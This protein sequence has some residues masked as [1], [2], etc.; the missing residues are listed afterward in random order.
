MA[1]LKKRGKYYYIRFQKMVDGENT[2]STKSLGIRYKVQAQEAKILLEEMEERGEINPYNGSFD[3]KK[4]LEQHQHRPDPVPVHTVREAADYFYKLKSHLSDKTVRNDDKDRSSKRGAYERAIEHFISLNDIATLP[5]KQVG[6]HHFEKV[7]FKPGIKSATRHFYYRQLR[8]WWN[9]L[10]DRD[11]VTGNFFKTLKKNL[12]DK[13]SNMRPKM[14]TEDELNKLFKAFDKEVDRKKKLK[15]WKPYYGQR[16]FKPLICCYFYGGLRKNEAGYDPDTDYSG[17]QG[18]NLYYEDGELAAIYLEATKGRNERLIPL[19]KV[20]R[21]YL[22]EYIA[23]R[24]VP[25]HEEYLFIYL[26]G[27]KKGW[28]VTGDRAYRQFKRYLEEA[29]LPKSRTLHGMRHER[30]TSWLEDGYNTS[31]AQFMA[32][33]SSSNVTNKYTHLRAKKLLKKQ[34]DIENNNSD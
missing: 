31:E 8:V 29:G 17:L 3:P 21:T 22:Q 11:I 32:G 28:P 6:L 26:G 33:H 30:I 23:V 12:P 25:G 27:S 18:K 5:V 34:R 9:D 14:L 16:W 19:N 24:G 7:I 2:E 4:I 1:S 13:K 10:R 15:E 20:W